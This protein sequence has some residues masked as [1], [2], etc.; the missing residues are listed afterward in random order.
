MNL[1]RADM[2]EIIYPGQYTNLRRFTQDTPVLPDVW[3]AYSEKPESAQR[4]LLT[5]HFDSS[6]PQLFSALRSRLAAER[7]RAGNADALAIFYNES[8]VLAEVRFEELVRV[9]L[10]LS[11]WW[12][13]RIWSNPRQ[14]LSQLLNPE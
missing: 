5:P 10:P 11:V 3:T 2:M 7:S 1:A 8:N 6:A 14:P 13:K 4:L 12:Q 9:V